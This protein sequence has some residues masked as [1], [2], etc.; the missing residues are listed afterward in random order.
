MHP[1]HRK[2]ALW[3]VV[4]VG[5]QQAPTLEPA[6]ISGTAWGPSS[7]ARGRR[8]V[9]KRLERAVLDEDGGAAAGNEDVGAVAR[10][11]HG[12]EQT[13]V[14]VPIPRSDDHH[15]I[16]LVHSAQLAQAP[17]AAVCMES[18]RPA[19]TAPHS[20]SSN[21]LK[22]A[23]D[24]EEAGVSRRKEHASVFGRF[25]RLRSIVRHQRAGFLAIQE[26][27]LMRLSVLP[28]VFTHGD[29]L[30][31]VGDEKAAF[32]KRNQGPLSLE[33]LLRDPQHCLHC[34]MESGEISRDPR[35]LS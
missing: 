23:G 29:F 15:T 3:A 18:P 33:A 11:G 35:H 1:K 22:R 24:V 28:A 10:G 19:N 6:L 12:A 9:A 30:E 25:L 2:P 16:F 4:Q 34:L 14:E 17:G 5:W 7:P 21:Q 31:L 20:A 13:A 32:V 8:V 26:D 27:C